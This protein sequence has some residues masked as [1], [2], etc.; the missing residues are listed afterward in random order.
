MTLAEIKAL[1]PH[2]PLYGI[3]DEAFAP[4]GRRL[5][6]DTEEIVALAEKMPYPAEGTE[7][8]PSVFSFEL[9]GLMQQ[10][11]DGVFGTLPIQMGYCHGHSNRLNG[12]EWHASSEVNVACTDLVLI[13]GHVWEIENGKIDSSVAKAFFLQKGDIAEVYA[14]S[15]HFCPCQTGD[16]FKCVVALP[17]GTNVPL[18]EPA[19]DPLLFRKNKWILAHNDNQPLIDRG[20]VPGISG[21]NFEIRGE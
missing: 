14:T 7:Y 21:E 5:N 2:L 8:L 9:T 11:T 12:W 16:G 20:V 4:Y 19:E 13:L 3:D 18:D 10:I 6:Y 1:N 15:L 17:V